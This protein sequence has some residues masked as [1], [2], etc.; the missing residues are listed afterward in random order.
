MA[1]AGGWDNDPTRGADVAI[2]PLEGRDRVLVVNGDDAARAAIVRRYRLFTYQPDE[3]S[4]LRALAGMRPAHLQLDPRL[5]QYG[6]LWVYP[7]GGLLELASRLGYVS[8]RPD[9]VWYLDHPEAFGHMYVVARFYSA[10]WGLAGVAAIFSIV[11]RISGSMCAAAVA[12]IC[13]AWMPVVVNGAHEAKP[14]LAGTVLMLLATI[15]AA[16]YAEGGRRLFWMLAECFAE[17][18][19]GW[20]QPHT[21]FF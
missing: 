20:C 21:R 16:K 2:A 18:P 9:V 17:P 12:A 4:T 7:V 1:L 6:G 5:Y 10:L 15:A 8:I 14:H 3:M 19:R 13:F 11:R